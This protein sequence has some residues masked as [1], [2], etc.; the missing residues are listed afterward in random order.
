MHPAL[1]GF[2]QYVNS[3]NR[4]PAARSYP[5]LLTPLQINIPW[6]KSYVT[7]LQK[8]RHD[9]QTRK[10]TNCFLLCYQ[11][12][13]LAAARREQW[14]AKY[15][16]LFTNAVSPRNRKALSAM[17]VV[18]QAMYQQMHDVGSLFFVRHTFPI[19]QHI[20]CISIRWLLYGKTCF[21]YRRLR[22][23]RV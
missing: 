2:Q 11:W 8:H 22:G 20:S 17:L 15:Q 5:T 12:M 23:K 6:S 21:W 4:T 3:P 7:E 18:S 14:N 1:H 16:L 19:S 13:G 9:T 10:L